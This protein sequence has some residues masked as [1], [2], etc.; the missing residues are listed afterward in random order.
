MCIYIYIYIYIYS[1]DVLNDPLTLNWLRFITLGPP[2][3]I[4]AHASN[5]SSQKSHTAKQ[6]MLHYTGLCK[7]KIIIINKKNN[8][9]WY[10]NYNSPTF[11]PSPTTVCAPPPPP[12]PELH[13]RHLWTD[14]LL[15][16]T[17]YPLW[18][19]QALKMSGKGFSLAH[20]TPPPPP[21]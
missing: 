13:L 20:P 1:L 8:K 15:F 9:N 5:G 2:K 16:L 3:H 17:R 6:N 21:S 19:P 11:P 4:L 18:P 14:F 7:K 10:K 12:P